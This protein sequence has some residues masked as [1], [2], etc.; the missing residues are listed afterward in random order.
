LDEKKG[1]SFGIRV[2]WDFLELNGID[3]LGFTGF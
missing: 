3:F 2:K 1:I